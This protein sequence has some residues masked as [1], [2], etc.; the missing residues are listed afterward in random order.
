MIGLVKDDNH[1]TDSLL[2][3][4][5]IIPL[6]KKSNLYLFLEAIQDEVHRFAISYHKDTRS[7][8]MFISG[9]DKIKGI[10]KVRKEQVLKILGEDD[11]E[12]KLNEL[13]LSQNQIS[14]ILS[15]YKKN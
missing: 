8:N 9:L 3:N 11:F 5:R 12:S 15:L 7:K 1:K 4:D 14:E 10:G 6:D 2:Y 13:S